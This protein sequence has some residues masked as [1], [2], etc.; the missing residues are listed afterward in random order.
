MQL[1]RQNPIAG[2]FGAI[3][4]SIVLSSCSALQ[5]NPEPALTAAPTSAIGACTQQQMASITAGNDAAQPFPAD[6]VGAL[7][8]AQAHYANTIAEY[9]AC[10]ASH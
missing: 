10:L 8:T 2:I 5:A 7:M 4:I 3:L 1:R 6:S 9:H